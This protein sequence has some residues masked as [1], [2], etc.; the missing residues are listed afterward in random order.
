MEAQVA[1][2]IFRSTII[3]EMCP[4]GLVLSCSSCPTYHVG[5]QLLNRLVTSTCQADVS[6]AKEL[7]L[8]SFYI[9]I[10]HK[11]LYRKFEY[12][13]RKLTFDRCDIEADSLSNIQLRL[14]PYFILTVFHALTD[15]WKH[16]LAIMS[17]SW[18][19]TIC[20]IISRINIKSSCKQTWHIH[21]INTISYQWM[22]DFKHGYMYKQYQTP[23]SIPHMT[24]IISQTSEHDGTSRT[25]L[26]DV[27]PS[28]GLQY[29]KCCMLSWY[30]NS[31]NE[32]IFIQQI[33]YW[34]SI[35]IFYHPCLPNTDYIKCRSWLGRIALLSRDYPQWECQTGILGQLWG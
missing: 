30:V 11:R 8:Y 29:I 34:L 24:S 13:M 2:E 21:T 5:W 16:A 35:I 19:L 27:R 10:Y 20:F 9:F 3:K 12:T 31:N 17:W 7:K 18:F 28:E 1:E 26:F 6:S 22:F 23:E 25:R 33:L 4:V 14:Y 15:V 32:T